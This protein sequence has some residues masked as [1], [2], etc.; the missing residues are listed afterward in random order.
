VHF[1]PTGITVTKQ[2][3]IGA[4]KP[5]PPSLF[6]GFPGQTMITA[7]P[8]KPM[9]VEVSGEPMRTRLNAWERRSMARGEGAQVGAIT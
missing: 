3:E 6:P 2:E 9:L 8:E 1:I 5:E 4:P 7:P